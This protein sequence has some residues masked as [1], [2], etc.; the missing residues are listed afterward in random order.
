MIILM[1]LMTPNIAAATPYL[2]K[3]INKDANRKA[4]MLMVCQDA[5][6]KAVAAAC[7]AGATCDVVVDLAP[8]TSQ[9]TIKV[10]DDA[11]LWSDP[12]NSLAAQVDTFEKWCLG[13]PA[14]RSDFDASHT[15][16]VA[17]FG[18]FLKALGASW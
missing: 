13:L 5:S 6:C 16:T 9:L 15:V 7:D 8:G 4:N 18:Q 14:C 1:I 12:S 10:S 11:V 3:F 17:D 2:V